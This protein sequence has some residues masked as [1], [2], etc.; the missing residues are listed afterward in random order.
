MTSF[1]GLPVLAPGGHADNIAMAAVILCTLRTSINSEWISRHRELYKDR[2]LVLVKKSTDTGSE[3]R[4]K[5]E[6][7]QRGLDFERTIIQ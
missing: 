5:I 1:A 4:N 7:Q 3:G 2:Y 6:V